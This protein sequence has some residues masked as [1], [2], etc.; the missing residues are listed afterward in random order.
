MRR[1]SWGSW[2]GSRA[3]SHLADVGHES[4]GASRSSLARSPARRGVVALPGGLPGSLTDGWAQEPASPRSSFSLLAG[5]GSRLHP[6]DADIQGGLQAAAAR[7]FW[8]RGPGQ[9]GTLAPRSQQGLE[10]G[11]QEP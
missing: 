6:S 7:A 10:T 1:A 5:A 3:P 4:E 11:Y 9:V 2:G 8:R